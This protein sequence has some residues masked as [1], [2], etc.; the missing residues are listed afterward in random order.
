[1]LKIS[2]SIESIIRLGKGGVEVG[3]D[4]NDDNSNCNSDSDRKFHLRFQLN[5][6]TTHFNTQDK[7][8]NGLIN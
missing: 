5:N 2:G 6:C 1:M 4:S 3:N 8:I 7:L